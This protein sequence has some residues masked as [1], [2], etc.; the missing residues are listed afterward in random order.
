M[1]KITQILRETL[2]FGGNRN[3]KHTAQV[4]FACIS[5]KLGVVAKK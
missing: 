4:I 1:M 3:N 2:P 5:W